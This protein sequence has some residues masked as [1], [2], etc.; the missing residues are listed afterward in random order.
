MRKTIGK[1]LLF[2]MFITSLGSNISFAKDGKIED[3]LEKELNSNKVVD[4]LIDVKD[5]EKP[6]TKVDLKDDEEK[7][8]KTREKYISEIKRNTEVSQRDIVEFLEDNKNIDEY[9]SFYITNTIRVV[10]KGKEIEKLSKLENVISVNKNDDTSLSSEGNLFESSELASSNRWNFNKVNVDDVYDKYNIKGQGIVIG[11]IDSGVDYEHNELYENWLGHTEGVEYSWY[12]VFGEKAYPSDGEKSGHGTA[13]TGISVGKRVGIAPEAKWI[14]AR[15]FK[16]KTSKDSDIL[17]AAEWMLHPGGKADKAPDIVNSSWGR[18]TK[19][20]W[21]DKMIAS[22]ISA[23]IVPVFASGNNIKGN[24][25]M[26]S[27]EYPASNLDVISVGAI[28]ENNNIGYFSKKGPSTLDDTGSIIKPEIVAPGVSVYTSIPGNFYSYWTG[29]SLATPNVSG[30]VALML[31]A[32]R[33]LGLPQ[34]KEILTSTANSIIDEDNTSTPNMTYGYGVVNALKAVEMSLMYGDSENVNRIAGSNRNNTA[35]KIADKFYENADIVYITN[36]NVYADGLSMG[37]LTK[38]DNGPLLLTDKDSIP[39]DLLNLL[40]KIKPA[41]IM[42]IGGNNVVSKEVEKSL[43]SY[44]GKVERLSGTSRIDTSIEIAK[45]VKENS[46]TDEMFIVNGYNEADSINIVS[47]ASRDGIPV[48]FTEKDKLPSQ[49][50]EYLN[51]ENIDKITIIGGIG[52]V[53]NNVMRDLENL[54]I[55]VTRVSGLD[56]FATGVEVNRKYYSDIGVLFFANGYNIADALSVGPVAGRLGGQIQIV[57]KDNITKDIA[58]FYNGKDI[59]EL[60]IL[61]GKNSITNINAYN[62]ENLFK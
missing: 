2:S 12:D 39:S 34:I 41:K 9:E 31:Q 37:S 57:P 60:Y 4:V 1:I 33:D 25:P 55:E 49:I 20:R 19:D 40:K 28:D 56:R 17:K 26:G 30:V 36:G 47:V 23:G 32:N 8:V 16:E 35:V 59:E 38:F 50:K 22:W 61:G 14:A 6:K 11:F 42:I 62:I 29:T 44:A 58:N 24:T 54:N 27:I 51:R 43:N 10:G 21:F 52:T 7:I 53:S 3:A 15:A 13:I 45:K 46:D 48:L 5:I 18:E